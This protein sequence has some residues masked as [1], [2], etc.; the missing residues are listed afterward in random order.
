[1]LDDILSHVV[2]LYLRLC[3]VNAELDDLLRPE[4]EQL[5]MW[6]RGLARGLLVLACLILLPL[7]LALIML[8]LACL[9]GL[10]AICGLEME[11]ALV[12]TCIALLLC[13]FFSVVL[14]TSLCWCRLE[15]EP[16]GVALA[17]ADLLRTTPQVLQNIWRFMLG[18]PVA[19]LIFLAI[20][21]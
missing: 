9:C 11:L 20:C 12:A 18:L 3:F 4:L 16:R 5:I 19:I 6:N 2:Y 8:P 7:T 21:S 13:H 17:M 15:W 14:L 10:P 1:M